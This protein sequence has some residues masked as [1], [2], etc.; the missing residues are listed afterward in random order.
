M[1]RAQLSLTDA[2]RR[3]STTPR[4]LASIE[5]CALGRGCRDCPDRSE[6]SVARLIY[7]PAVRLCPPPEE[8]RR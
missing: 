8:D 5:D 7:G 2:A 3:A 4:P 1:S 6:C